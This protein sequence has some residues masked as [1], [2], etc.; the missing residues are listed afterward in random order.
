VSNTNT[1]FAAAGGG[2]SD[3]GVPS[4]TLL[5]IQ[6]CQNFDLQILFLLLPL[7]KPETSSQTLFS[8][9][10]RNSKTP[11]KFVPKIS[12]NDAKSLT[13]PGSPE[14]ETSLLKPY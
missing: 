2:G 10:S 7:I 11:P 13:I 8:K 12:E 9:H 1:A 4:E 6:F 14:A 3:G 5:E